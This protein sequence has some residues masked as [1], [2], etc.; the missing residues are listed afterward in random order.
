MN[1]AIN[2]AIFSFTFLYRFAD[3]T[4]LVNDHFMHVAWGRQLLWGARP[5]RD[6]VPLGMPLQTA[7]SAAS[8]WLF[9]YRLLSE[10]VIIS[11]PS[12]A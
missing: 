5:I 11:M 4:G 8:E 3:A 7:L 12:S 6:A 10:A 1:R 9:G 2:T